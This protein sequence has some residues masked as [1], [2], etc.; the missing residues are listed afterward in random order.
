MPQVSTKLRQGKIVCPQCGD[1]ASRISRR[2][3]DRLVSLFQPMKRYRCDFCGW[4][5]NIAQSGLPDQ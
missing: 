2:L 4:T 1:L 5:G 3:Y